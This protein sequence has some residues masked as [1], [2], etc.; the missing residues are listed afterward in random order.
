MLP[1]VKVGL[2]R[3]KATILPCLLPPPLPLDFNFK[4]S[5][6][7]H[8]FNGLKCCRLVCYYCFIAIRLSWTILEQSHYH[9]LPSY[10]TVHTTAIIILRLLL[11]APRKNGLLP[12]D[13]ILYLCFLW[14]DIALAGK[15][16]T[17]WGQSHHLALPSSSPPPPLQFYLFSRPSENYH[18]NSLHFQSVPWLHKFSLFTFISDPSTCYSGS[19]WTQYSDTVSA[20]IPNPGFEIIDPI[21]HAIKIQFWTKHLDFCLHVGTVITLHIRSRTSKES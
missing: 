7:G 6:A 17:I 2:S 8:H 14:L 21:L 1:P 18:I 12:L 11:Q 5:I 3:D 15:A 13:W 4:F 10:S 16:Q 9:K 19:Y 20:N